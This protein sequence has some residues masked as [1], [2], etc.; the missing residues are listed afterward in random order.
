MQDREDVTRV[1]HEVSKTGLSSSEMSETVAYIFYLPNI[2]CVYMW[3]HYLPVAIWEGFIFLK[4]FLQGDEPI[5]KGVLR[6]KVLKIG[7]QLKFLFF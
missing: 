4:E 5:K 3:V 1:S 7:P 6:C 2:K